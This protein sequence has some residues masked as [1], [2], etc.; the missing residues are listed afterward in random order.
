MV[1]FHFDPTPSK[2]WILNWWSNGGLCSN[3]PSSE[4]KQSQG[5]W[6]RVLSIGL[7]GWHPLH[8]DMSGTG[9]IGWF[10]LFI[11]TLR[12]CHEGFRPSVVA[13]LYYRN[14][15]SR[16]MRAVFV[17][18]TLRGAVHNWGFC[19]ESLECITTA[20]YLALASC[21]QAKGPLVQHW[22]NLSATTTSRLHSG[23]PARLSACLETC[24][25]LL[26]TNT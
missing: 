5:E 25:L 9:L 20:S 24:F 3:W 19:L 23:C 7:S 8:R 1:A 13:D 16:E 22:C 12:R 11:A 15:P 17:T 26:K 6:S 4:Q 18:S 21:R 14:G 2:L 10:Y